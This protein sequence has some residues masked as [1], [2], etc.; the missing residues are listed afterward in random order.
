MPYESDENPQNAPH[1]RGKLRQQGIV[2][3]HSNICALA[4]H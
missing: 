3:V 4:T 1:Y 2:G